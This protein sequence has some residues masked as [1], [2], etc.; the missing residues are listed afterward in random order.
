MT[1]RT[2]Q[3]MNARNERTSKGVASKAA[4]ALQD[5]KAGKREKSI[6]GSA[7]TQSDTG[8]DATLRKLVQRVESALTALYGYIGRRPAKAK[9]RKAPLRAK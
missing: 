2:E 6:A 3:R 4:K 1:K 7:L 5:P 9:Q 8:I